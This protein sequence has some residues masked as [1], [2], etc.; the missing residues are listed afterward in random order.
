M[1]IEVKMDRFQNLQ[2][3]LNG[4]QT[5]AQMRYLAHVPNRLFSSDEK[6][7]LSYNWTFLG[8]FEAFKSLKSLKISLVF[9]NDSNDLFNEGIDV[10]QMQFEKKLV[11]QAAKKCKYDPY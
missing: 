7:T 4:K 8:I 9:M 10:A 2:N 3:L 5:L 11:K 6:Q 1:D